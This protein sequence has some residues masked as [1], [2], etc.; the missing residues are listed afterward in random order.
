MFL[1]FDAVVNIGILKT[2]FKGWIEG[3]SVFIR[4]LKRILIEGVIIPEM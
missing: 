4:E 2:T 1:A 3:V